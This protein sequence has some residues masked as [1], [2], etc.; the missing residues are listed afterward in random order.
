MLFDNECL[1]TLPS[2]GTTAPEFLIFSC[3]CKRDFRIAYFC[4]STVGDRPPLVRSEE[5]LVRAI[6]G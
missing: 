6:K 2:F 5:G 1:S 4:N 3:K